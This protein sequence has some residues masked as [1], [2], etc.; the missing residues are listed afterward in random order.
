MSA[1]TGRRLGYVVSRF[2]RVT[3]TFILREVLAMDELGWP[4]ELFAM[5]HEREAVA[6]ADAR[7]IERKVHYPSAWPTLASNLR[8]M[9]RQPETWARFLSLTVVGNACSGSF[10]VKSLL[11]FPIA[12]AWAGQ[13]QSLGVRHVHAHFGSYPALAALV[14]AGLQG[15][16]FSFTL[17]AHDLFADNVMLAEKARRA[18]FVVAISDF[19]R[20]WTSSLLA[21]DTA[22]RVRVV[23]CGV[24]TRAFAFTPRRSRTLPHM[25]L[26]V[27][28]LRDYKGLDHLIRACALLRNSVPEQRFVCRIVG[29]GPERR[30]L[31]QLIQESGLDDSVLLMGACEEREVRALLEN[32]DTFVLPSVVARNGY[33][34]GIPV[35]LMEAMATGVPVI[36]SRLSGI[37]ELVCDG[38]TGLLVPSCRADAI[39]DAIL[40]CWDEPARAAQRAVRARQIVERDYDVNRNARRL[41]ALFEEV[42]DNS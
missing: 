36:A 8:L 31:Q 40:R 42:L 2:P 41:A 21:P 37:P 25:I 18:R 35:A 13:M 1:V 33:M 3:E 20:D 19:N 9:A 14:A 29:E 11:V 26:S 39:H 5:R 15:I 4:I 22:Q 30:A 32:S 27:A 7:R 16:G 34:D 10:L 6:H 28:A 17:H 12:V 38:D 23:R 24:D